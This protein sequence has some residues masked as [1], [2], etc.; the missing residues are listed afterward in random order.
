[1]TE[2]VRAVVHAPPRHAKTETCLA[3]VAWALDDNPALTHAYATYESNLAK[4]KSRKVRDYVGMAGVGLRGDSK[5]LNEWRTPEGGGLLAT[6]VMGPLTGQG[7]SGLL[8]VDDPIKNR[9]D[10][11][12]RLMRDRTYDWFNDVA[13]TRMEPTGSIIVVMTRWH[14]DDLAGRL[15]KLGCEVCRE[16]GERWAC[17]EDCGAWDS[18]YLPALDEQGRALWPEKYSAEALRSIRR[19]IGEYSWAS[20]YQGHPR[21][22]GAGVFQDATTY[23]VLPTEG[24]RWGAG[25]DL[26]YSS[27]TK[28][29]AS[30][31]GVMVKVAN[32]LNPK[33]PK[34]YLVDVRRKQA[35]S[36]PAFK[37]ILQGQRK[38]FPRAP[39]PRWYAAGTEIGAADFFTKVDPKVPIQVVAARGDKFTRAQ[40]YAAAWNAGDVLVPE[41]ATWVDEFLLEHAAFT[42]TDGE[43]DDQVDMSV[44]AYDQLAAAPAGF[45]EDDEKF[46]APRR[47]GLGEG[48]PPDEYDEDD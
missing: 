20:L 27:K 32:P 42:G 7:V 9:V 34:Y 37:L 48:L 8:L 23:S 22:R 39:P 3:G 2:P 13:Y 44:G 29:D 11:E 19:Q 21:P 4:S 17:G 46:T 31:C 25:L 18:L 36:A 35:T 40:S 45:D 15:L 5:A 10:A 16:A 33:R 26:A 1:M 6:G 28:L 41:V 24:L 43:Q 47:P 12:S 30:V 38:A 14:E